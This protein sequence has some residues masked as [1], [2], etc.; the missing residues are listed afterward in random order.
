LRSAPLPS[1]L[2][3]GE[4]IEPSV[5]ENRGYD[6]VNSERLIRSEFYEMSNRPTKMK[7]TVFIVF[8][9]VMMFMGLLSIP[10][11][12]P[13]C[14]E[15]F[16]LPYSGGHQLDFRNVLEGIEGK[17][18]EELYRNISKIID[19]PVKGLPG[20]HRY[21]GHWGFEGDIPFNQYPLK[22]ILEKLPAEQKASMINKITK[23]W[24]SR[25][26]NINVFAESLTGLP[27]RQA[28][29]LA[30]L[31][32][33]THLLGD[34][35]PGNK[36]VEPL[37]NVVDIQKDI[38]KNLHRLFGNNSEFVRRVA[39]E[40]RS[41]PTNISN[42]EYADEVLKILKRNSIGK[43]LFETYAKLL[44]NFSIKY[45]PSGW[46]SGKATGASLAR[47]TSA[48]HA[49]MKARKLKVPG[50]KTAANAAVLAGIFSTI[51]H[52]WKVCEDEESASQALEGVCK[53][54][55]LAAGSFYVA[56]GLIQNLG[57]G[58]YAI[59]AI[60]KEGS[61]Q[62]VKQI[63]AMV[64]YGLATFIFDETT[65]VYNYVSGDMTSEQFFNESSKSVIK[66]TASGTA[67]YCAVLIGAS[68]GGPVIMAVSIGTYMVVAKAINIYEKYD[69]NQ[70]FHL[71]DY[72]G[73]LPIE[74][75]RRPSPWNLLERT[76]PWN[77][78]LR[79][80]PWKIRLRTDPWEI[81]FRSGPWDIK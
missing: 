70:H 63:G 42:Q 4:L 23:E 41:I 51:V 20:N 21:F 1:P 73:K 32:Y 68:P 40:I 30:G 11:L 19:T 49:N 53:D 54:T 76:D 12:G 10:I 56:E 67:A 72:L 66:S 13:W 5:F 35:V 59:S 36:I 22:S 69:E 57:G 75:Q 52:S 80:D 28:K 77:I 65:H 17:N 14:T 55:A 3:A 2:G 50:L 48:T 33:N 8:L 15:G 38:I 9:Y 26:Q 44:E 61:A 27:K 7:L 58:K 64:N 37:L 31:I 46:R 45:N 43:K 24:H 6:M 74:A 18:I 47:A 71:S 34:W 78:M 79:S 62:S 81:K 16:A 29:A 25:V 60:V 39:E